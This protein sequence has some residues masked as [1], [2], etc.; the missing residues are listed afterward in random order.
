MSVAVDT[1]LRDF[2][3]YTGD[4]LPNAPVGAPLPIGDPSSGV[5]NPSKAELRNAIGGVADQ[6][7]MSAAQAAAYGGVEVVTFA[8]LVALTSGTVSVGDIVRV[9]SIDAIYQRL[10][11]GGNLTHTAST[12][13]WTVFPTEDGLDVRAFGAVGDGT[14][15]DSPSFQAAVNATPTI[16]GSV[17]GGNAS[18][19]LAAP[20]TMSGKVDLR[21]SNCKV[22]G[23]A[24]RF[25]G[26][27]NVSGSDGVIFDNVTFD[28][29]FGVVTQFLPAHYASGSFNVGVYGTTC[30]DVTVINSRFDRLYTRSINLTGAGKLTVRGCAFTSP[31]QNQTQ[32]LDYIAILTSR[33]LEVVGNTF[34]SAAT[35]K[36][37]GTCAVV[38]SGITEAVL[39]ADNETNWCGRDNT[40]THRLGVFDG[41]FD[42][43]N[44]RISG[45][46]SRNCLAQFVRAS[47]IENLEII[48]NIVH[49]AAAAE[50]G[51]SLISLEGGTFTGTGV[52]I[53]N[54]KVSGNIINDPSLRSAVHVQLVAYDWGATSRDITISNNTF[55]GSDVA[56]LVVGPYNGMRIENNVARGGPGRINLNSESGGITLTAVQGTQINARMRGLRIAG[57][58]LECT[59]TGAGI[60]VSTDKTPIFTGAM[61]DGVIEGN[62]VVNLAATG[63]QAIVANPRGTPKL[64]EISIRGNYTRGFDVDIYPRECATVR[65]LNN[66]GNGITAPYS[67]DA[68]NVVEQRRG[69]SGKAGRLFGTATLVAGGAGI[70]NTEVRTDDAGKIMITRTIS[71]GTLGH[72]DVHTIVNATSFQLRSSSGA[73]TS[74]VF[75]EIVR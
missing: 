62:R 41:Y 29:M 9:A 44:V 31:V 8:Q 16:L 55:S 54:A 66:D 52:A 38:Y 26:Y 23:N 37:F 68:T 33:A 53:R 25:A 69:N 50:T 71:G 24:T 27:F 20:I 39:I 21:I 7:A 46:L 67:S 34:L 35:T 59:G 22:L 5:H 13:S 72:L 17:H 11:S 15:D 48:D 63:A 12:L 75:W 3:R 32:I 40:G 51:Y 36:D 57:N 61:I 18:F 2:V 47:A 30:G 70:G 60:T 43:K 65:V 14:T 74:T 58:D 49:V 1:A 19:R 10:A 6:A 28:H 45:N 64:A 42:A 73:D 56:I 4:G